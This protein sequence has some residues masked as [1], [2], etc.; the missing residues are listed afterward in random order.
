[1]KTDYELGECPT[2]DEWQTFFK[3]LKFSV[4]EDVAC[5]LERNDKKVTQEQFDTL[6]DRVY[7]C[8]GGEEQWELISYIYYD[9][10]A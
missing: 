5:W 3:V 1:M 6:C 9:E 2:N 10:I 8:D 4:K 7:D